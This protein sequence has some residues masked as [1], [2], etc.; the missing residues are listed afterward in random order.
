MDAQ[1]RLV[2]MYQGHIGVKIGKVMT[3]FPVGLSPSTA[4]ACAICMKKEAKETTAFKFACLLCYG[5]YMMDRMH[6]AEFNF[7]VHA[8]VQVRAQARKWWHAHKSGLMSAWDK[9]LLVVICNQQQSEHGGDK[10]SCFAS[11]IPLKLHANFMSQVARTFDQVCSACE[12]VGV[13]KTLT[14]GLSSSLGL[15]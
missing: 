15:C 10:H 3:V 2:R 8:T 14:V 1:V 7:C 6:Q 9:E 11:S 5:R 13:W 4:R 12:E